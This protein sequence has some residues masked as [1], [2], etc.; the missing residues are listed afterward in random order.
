MAWLGVWASTLIPPA[1]PPQFDDG[2]TL[3][4]FPAAE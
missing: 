3:V 2:V 1:I 4:H